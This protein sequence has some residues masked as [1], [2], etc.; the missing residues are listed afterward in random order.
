MPK[1]SLNPGNGPKGPEKTI[2]KLN[3]AVDAMLSRVNNRPH[4]E[5]GKVDKE[6][7][8]LVRLAAELRNLPRERFKARLKS[9]LEGKKNMSTVAEPVVAKSAAT[10]PVTERSSAKPAAPPKR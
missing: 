10:K 1:R 7:E 2:E 5:A 3:Q 6:V 9:E 8:P 4:K